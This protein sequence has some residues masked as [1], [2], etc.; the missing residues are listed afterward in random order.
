MEDRSAVAS[1]RKP[2]A[3]CLLVV[4]LLGLLTIFYRGPGSDWV[5]DQLGGTFYVLAWI[6]LVLTAFPKLAPFR[7]CLAVLLGT[8]ALEFLQL[9]IVNNEL[10]E[11]RYLRLI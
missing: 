6:F 11:I 2:Y 10:L 1:K 7:V 5:S 9:W 3:L 8:C 4:V